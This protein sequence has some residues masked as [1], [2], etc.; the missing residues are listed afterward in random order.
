[1]ARRAIGSHIEAKPL[2]HVVETELVEMAQDD[3]ALG[4]DRRDMNHQDSGRATGT[5]ADSKPAA[6]DRGQGTSA[7][8]RVR[9]RWQK[10]SKGRKTKSEN[11]A[12]QTRDGVF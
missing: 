10:D 3:V 7:P 8:A 6:R 2:A 12:T 9:G 5:R 1:M 4:S 11:P